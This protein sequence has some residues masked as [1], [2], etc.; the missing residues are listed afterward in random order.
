[1]DVNGDEKVDL[2]VTRLNDTVGVYLGNGDGTFQQPVAF[3][4]GGQVLRWLAVGDVSGDRKPDLIVANMYRPNGG[5]G[6][7]LGNGDGGFQTPENFRSGGT[8]Q[9]M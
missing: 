5:V 7:L 4:S 8:R 1:M 6:V 3:S 2:L 9:I